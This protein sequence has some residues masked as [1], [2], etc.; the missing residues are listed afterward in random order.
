MICR[1]WDVS[2]GMFVSSFFKLNSEKC[3]VR[4]IIISLGISIRKELIYI[5]HEEQP[6]YLTTSS[7]EKEVISSFDFQNLFLRNKIYL[8]SHHS[9]NVIILIIF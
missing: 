2:Q 4:K 7:L 8:Y 9:F 1:L 3:R 6:Q 5:Y